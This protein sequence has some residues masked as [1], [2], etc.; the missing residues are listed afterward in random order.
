[1]QE[2]DFCIRGALAFSIFRRIASVSSQPVGEGG[3]TAS[4]EAS[5]VPIGYL[6]RCNELRADP[7]PAWQPGVYNPHDGGSSDETNV[8]FLYIR[9]PVH[10][11]LFLHRR[12]PSRYRRFIF[13]VCK[14]LCLECL[15]LDFG[16]YRT[17]SEGTIGNVNE[18]HHRFFRQ[19]AVRKTSILFSQETFLSLNSSFFDVALVC[20]HT[21]AFENAPSRCT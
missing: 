3:D 16:V 11:L 8:F 9:C 5:P 4:T 6:R 20:V 2:S 19:H 1:M 15:C 14:C 13:R 7:S 18:G 17:S 12:G 10:R 21:S